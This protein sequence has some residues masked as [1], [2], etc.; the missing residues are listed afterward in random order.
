MQRV[1]ADTVGK[2]AKVLGNRDA[3]YAIGKQLGH[4]FKPWGAVKGGAK[5]AKGG[6]VLGAVAAAA[7][8][9][10]MAD[11][12][13]RANDHKAEQDR[14]AK[15]VRAVADHLI[16]GLTVGDD[17]QGPV[18]FLQQAE[19]E[20]KTM[21]DDVTGRAEDTQHR[22]HDIDERIAIVERLIA[23]AELLSTE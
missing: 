1:A 14:A 15:T 3:V 21:T 23:A 5:I 9:K 8:V 11:D 22:V 6:A 18:G 13:K 16:R 17:K 12:G 19:R 20:L 4:K 10:K 7:D 2:F